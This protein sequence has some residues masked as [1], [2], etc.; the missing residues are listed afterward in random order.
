MCVLPRSYSLYAL[1]LLCIFFM[2]Q[3]IA[4][5]AAGGQGSV[6][7]YPVGDDLLFSMYSLYEPEVNRA[8]SDGFTAIGPYYGKKNLQ[9]SIELA[10]LAKLPI[11]Y[12]I[13]QKI[14]FK[15]DPKASHDRELELLQS[16]VAV[17]SQNNE[18]AAWVFANEEIRYWRPA[19]VSWLQA[20]TNAIRENDPLKRPIMMY[21][22][23]NRSVNALIQTSVYLDFVTKGAYA[24]FVGMKD[25]RTWVRY[26]IEQA[27]AAAKETKT[28][29]LAVLWM[30]RDQD[31]EADIAAIR[32]WTR[33]D[34]YLSLLTGAKGVLI[35]SGWSK[36]AGFKNHY[37]DFYKGYASAAS[38]LNGKL[39]LSHVF[40]YGK[41]E[42]GIDVSVIDGPKSQQF[43][44]L[45]ELHKYPTVSSKYLLY[46]GINYFF[47]INSANEDVSILIDGL[48]ID[49]QV[50]S[51]VTGALIDKSQIKVL[52][53]YDVIALTWELEQS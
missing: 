32:S 5:Q 14:D 28:T 42:T 15:A 18:I 45:D 34:V 41:E 2:R 27:V 3:A 48:P 51:V 13:G 40:L 44:Y 8:F 29:P 38:E 10:Q 53:K 9:R 25:N 21:E 33:H 49:K 6:H 36:R 4:L 19:E 7:F 23:N 39:K 22:P 17:A 47:I 43:Y 37:A 24:N 31:N 20:A 46:D 50:H 30:A 26:S 11:L 12:T 35:F 1:L 16:E 52:G